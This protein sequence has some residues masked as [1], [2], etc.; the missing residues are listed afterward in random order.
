MEQ[1]QEEEDNEIHSVQNKAV[2]REAKENA[3]ITRGFKCK[4]NIRSMVSDVPRLCYE[5]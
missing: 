1:E 4:K 2:C 3:S 5:T